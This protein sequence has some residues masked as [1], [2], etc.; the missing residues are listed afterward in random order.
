[1]RD[2]P[3]QIGSISLQGFEIP[4]SVRFGGR[5]RLAVHHLSGGN[6]IVERLGPDD[7]EVAFQGTCSGPDAEARVRTLDALRLSGAIVWLT[8]E[9]FRRRVIVS[10]FVA[11]YHSPW[12]IPYKVSCVVTHQPGVTTSQTPTVLALISADLGNA[13]SAAA[14]SPISLVTLQTALSATNAMTTGTSDQTQAVAA[15][16]T[17]L[18]AINT[19]ITVQSALIAAP[20]APN[21]S[22][23]SFSL[24]LPSLVS[25][26]AQLAAAVNV[27]SYVGRIGLNLNGSGD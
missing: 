8:W 11:E 1:M 3:I 2:S 4:T 25:N 27:R 10:N 18:N 13:L 23:G 6:R 14:G 7:G 9:T 19:Q 20:P 16:G 24:G 5:H 26:A 22:S 12:W 15:V 17:A 21:S